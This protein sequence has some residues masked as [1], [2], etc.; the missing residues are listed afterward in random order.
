MKQNQLNSFLKLDDAI[1]KLD[2]F[3]YFLHLEKKKLRS[4]MDLHAIF[5]FI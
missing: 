2:T 3:F 4:H 1:V 5:S